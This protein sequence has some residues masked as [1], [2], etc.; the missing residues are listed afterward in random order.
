MEL[1]NLLSVFV[2]THIIRASSEPYI[3]N[4][5]IVETIFQAYTKLGLTGVEFYVYPDDAFNETHPELMKNIMNTLK[6]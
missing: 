4:E 3:E 6:A 2:P 1:S 5:M